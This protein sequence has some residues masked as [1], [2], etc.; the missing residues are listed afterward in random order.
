M[1]TGTDSGHGTAGEQVADA[2]G[3]ILR[4]SSRSRLYGELTADLGPAVDEATY[5]VLSGL[6]RFGPIS[7]AGLGA[8]LG[9]DRSVV[10]R[11]ATRLE[12]GGLLRRERDPH[13]AR[14]SLLVL[15]ERGEPVVAELRRRLATRLDSYLAS[16]PPGQAVAFAEA[17]ARFTLEGPL[18]AASQEEAAACD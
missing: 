6:G 14:A 1:E 11:H 13:D 9:L 3:R 5:P 2:L 15:T 4:R 8:E 12:D 7:A 16:W 18:L 10:S 17:L